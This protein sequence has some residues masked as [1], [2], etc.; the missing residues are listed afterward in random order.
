MQYINFLTIFTTF[1][2]SKHQHV[3]FAAIAIE[4]LH[5]GIRNAVK[6]CKA[7]L[8]DNSYRLRAFR[9]VRSGLV[10]ASALQRPDVLLGKLIPIVVHGNV[11]L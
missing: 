1:H 2:L 4:L 5:S 7:I 10:E 11:V 8:F 3:Q 9:G 6:N